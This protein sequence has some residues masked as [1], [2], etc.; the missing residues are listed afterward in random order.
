MKNL[1]FLVLTLSFIGTTA[2]SDTTSSSKTKWRKHKEKANE[3][4]KT[5]KFNKKKEVESIEEVKNKVKTIDLGTHPE[6]NQVTTY[7]NSHFKKD[8]VKDIDTYFYKDGK[9]IKTSTQLGLYSSYDYKFELEHS[10]GTRSY[11]PFTPRAGEVD[12]E[13]FYPYFCWSSDFILMGDHH[14]YRFEFNQIKKEYGIVA[15][16]GAKP[17]TDDLDVLNASINDHITRAYSALKQAYIDFENNKFDLSSLKYE[18]IEVSY[19]AYKYGQDPVE[20]GLNRSLPGFYVRMKDGTTHISTHY[21]GL[22]KLGGQIKME[23]FEVN[24]DSS[25]VEISYCA[26]HDPRIKFTRKFGASLAYDVEIEIN[27]RDGYPG[28]LRSRGN[29]KGDRGVNGGD[30]KVS[31]KQKINDEGDK[32]LHVKIE[33]YNKT[34]YKRV[35]IGGYVSISATGGNGANG[36]KGTDAIDVFEYAGNGGDGG[37]GGNGGNVTL[38]VDPNVENADGWGYLDVPV[39]G[40]NAGYGGSP[41]ICSNC[42]GDGSVGSSGK[43]GQKGTFTFKVEKLDF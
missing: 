3:K 26:K 1:L 41:G 32:Y 21:N 9:W 8:N 4:G 28:E 6:Q 36:T 27:G 18:D 17:P 29:Y 30:V 2:Q 31:V 15:V 37:D 39:N 33:K 35:A 7:L 12:R 10:D 19:L 38:V 14:F 25:A 5:N 23:K 34:T 13:I 42:R 40:G 22:M 24:D 16:Y 11:I 43:P 20:E